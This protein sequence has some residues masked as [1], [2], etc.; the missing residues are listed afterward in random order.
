MPLDCTFPPAF[1]ATP[2]AGPP[3]WADPRLLMA[4][5]AVKTTFF[6]QVVL[7]SLQVAPA[8][9][10]RVA[11]GFIPSSN[12][13]VNLRVTPVGDPGF[14]G[15]KIATGATTLWF[16]LFTYGVLVNQAWNCNQ[17]NPLQMYVVEVYRLS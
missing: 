15:F 10:K 1:K 3:P 6:N 9:P 2:P 17:N 14:Y 5:T 4:A 13:V 7:T 12:V 8:D 16:D 11:L